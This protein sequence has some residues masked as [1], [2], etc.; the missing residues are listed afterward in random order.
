[1]QQLSALNT[2]EMSKLLHSNM[3]EYPNKN[4]FCVLILEYFLSKIHIVIYN[5][6]LCGGF[7]KNKNSKKQTIDIDIT[8][9]GLGFTCILLYLQ[10]LGFVTNIFLSLTP[11][12][13]SYV[14]HYSLL[15]FILIK[16]ARTKRVKRR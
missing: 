9:V 6:L 11:M 14:I 7:M 10:L 16:S 12:V 13:L 5:N 15:V 2:V 1:M 3:S 4:R 8:M